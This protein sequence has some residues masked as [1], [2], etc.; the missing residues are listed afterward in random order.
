MSN[1]EIRQHKEMAMGKDMD[2][3]YA[4]E[5]GFKGVNL[6]GGEEVSK[7]KH[8]KDGNRGLKHLSK[9]VDHGPHGMNEAG[10]Y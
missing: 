6:H 2:G 3:D 9:D 8:L 7:K 1:S 5:S 10:E 4:C